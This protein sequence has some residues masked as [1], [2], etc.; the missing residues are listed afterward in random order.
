MKEE[1]IDSHR[2]LFTSLK[3]LETTLKEPEQPA[4][5]TPTSTE[6]PVLSGSQESSLPAGSI[7]PGQT[8][9]NKNSLATLVVCTIRRKMAEEHERERVG[10]YAPY[11][12]GKYHLA[13][14]GHGGGRGI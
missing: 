7:Q 6:W 8:P 13:Y 14:L 2:D 9:N 3:D 12:Q 1:N 5:I 10:K 11:F 4:A